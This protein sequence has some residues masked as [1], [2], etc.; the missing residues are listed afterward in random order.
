ML[1][2]KGVFQSEIL[3]SLVGGLGY[4]NGNVRGRAHGNA[5]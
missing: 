1:V 4:G 3:M 5:F 2:N